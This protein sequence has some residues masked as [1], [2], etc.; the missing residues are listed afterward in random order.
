MKR[1][2][3]LCLALSACSSST[4]PPTID[5]LDYLVQTQCEDGAMACA[6]PRRQLVSDPMFWRRFD[7]KRYQA[8]DSLLAPDGRVVTTFSYPPFGPFTAANG[9]GG[10]VYER[11]GSAYYIHGTQHGGAPYHTF[12]DLWWIGDDSTPRS[13]WKDHGLNRARIETVGFPD[14]SS[15]DCLV[16]EH[17]DTPARDTKMERAYYCGG[18]WAWQVWTNPAIEARLPPKAADLP[19]RC[20]PLSWDGPPPEQSAMTLYDCRYS[21]QREKWDGKGSDYGWPQ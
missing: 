5:L 1:G 12:G 21:I 9:D 10:E 14:G 4:R 6:N 13:R 20:P 3:G 16:S 19:E 11:R 7:I 2:I 18:R 17:Y 8:N 15:R